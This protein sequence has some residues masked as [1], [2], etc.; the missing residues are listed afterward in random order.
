MKGTPDDDTDDREGT[1]EPEG[2]DEV[3]AYVDV[4]GRQFDEEDLDDDA[5]D[6]EPS[7]VVVS[8]RG[9][10]RTTPRARKT[11]T[12][13]KTSARVARGGRARRGAELTGGALIV[14]ALVG[15]GAYALA[16]EVLA[17]PRDVALVLAGL[18]AGLTP[19]AG[20]AILAGRK[21]VGSWITPSGARS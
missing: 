16:A 5:E 13:T 14:M 8:R 17:L 6:D 7:E 4:R 3:Y 20:R 19:L 11:K 9:R 2:T 12:P 1:G 18:A 21:R 10:R 15:F